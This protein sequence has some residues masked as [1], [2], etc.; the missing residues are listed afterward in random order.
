MD[1]SSLDFSGVEASG[2]GIL[3]PGSHDVEIREATFGKNSTG[4][5]MIVKVS[6]SSAEGGIRSTYNVVHKNEEARRIGQEQ[7]KALLINA[8][9]PNPD[10]PGDIS[11]LKGLK[12]G[13]RVVEDGEYNGKPSY[14]VASTF[15]LADRP[16]ATKASGFLDDLADDIPL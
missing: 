8:G 11:T 7:F 12:V 9:H 10:R 15:S 1:F 4:T 2:G 16:P 6:F 14:R 13:I 3:S 5:G